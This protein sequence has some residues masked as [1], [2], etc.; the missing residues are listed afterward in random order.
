MNQYFSA[1]LGEKKESFFSTSKIYCRYTFLDIK[2][3]VVVTFTMMGETVPSSEKDMFH[4]VWAHNY[5]IKS[6]FN[7]VSFCCLDTANW[8]RDEE[9]YSIL[10]DLKELISVFPERIGYGGSMGGFAVLCFGNALGIE[11]ILAMN[12]IS[13]LNS[14]L[15][16]FETRFPHYRKTLDWE[17]EFSDGGAYKG[18]GYIVYDPLFHLDNLHAKIIDLKPLKLAGVG[19][20]IPMHMHKM[21][22]LKW[23]VNG[24]LH[25][26]PLE[27]EFYKKARARRKYLHYY[28]WLLSE[29]NIHITSRRKEVITKYKDA[30]EILSGTKVAISNR[31]INKLRD[32][33]V[34]I[35]NSE[36]NSSLLILKELTKV[37]PKGKYIKNKIAEYDSVLKKKSF[38]V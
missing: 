38:D 8:Y 35:E 36:M 15:A 32:V 26:T 22:M 34:N 31:S 9:F 5:I 4:D 33:A 21:G 13:T 30:Q 24:F 25:N 6:G 20:S 18:K 28:E 29:E 3:P 2:K 37:R 10:N 19:H 7:C 23:L 14:N 12:P 1:Y 27:N 17:S 11:R 16:P